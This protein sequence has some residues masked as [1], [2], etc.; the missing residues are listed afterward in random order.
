MLFRSD[1]P[2][3]KLKKQKIGDTQV[4]PIHKDNVNQVRTTLSQL[5]LPHQLITVDDAAMV[6]IAHDGSDEQ[7]AQADQIE[8]VISKLE[9]AKGLGTSSDKD[10]SDS[11]S[12]DDSDSSDSSDE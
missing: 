11:D 12:Q 1:V 6:V 10:K 4:I 3:D 7:K 8:K 9:A 5:Q 2:A